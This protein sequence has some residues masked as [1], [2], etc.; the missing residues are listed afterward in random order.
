[1]FSVLV[2]VGPGTVP[3][4][5]YSVLRFEEALLSVKGK[6]FAVE[7]RDAAALDGIVVGR[8]RVAFVGV[9]SIVWIDEVLLAH[10]FIAVGLGQN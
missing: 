1:M 6:A 9:P 10:E 8:G 4:S 7:R 5:L 3:T 2:R